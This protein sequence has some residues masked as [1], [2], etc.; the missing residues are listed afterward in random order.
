MKGGLP[1]VL[2][3]GS[4]TLVSC[5]SNKML[6]SAVTAREITDLQQFETIADISLIE[7]ANKEKYNDTLSTKS[8]ELLASVLNSFADRI[9]LT[10]EISVRDPLINKRL[11]REIEHLRV[12]AEVQ[13]S[14]SSIRLT[15]R[16]DSLL[17]VNQKRFGL[18]TVTKGFTRKRGNYGKQIANGIGLGILTLGMVYTTPVKSYS[19]VYAMIVDAENNNIAF[20]NKSFFPEGEPLD[21]VVLKQQVLDIFAGYFWPK[22]SKN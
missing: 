22:N 9:P 18:I 6:T 14:L 20:F 15:P 5:A 12:S 8:K 16:L 11:A 19:V 1:L 7:K 3:V 21:E 10:G 2:L 4:I 17:E 13:K